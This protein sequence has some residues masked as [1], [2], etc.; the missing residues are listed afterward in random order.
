MINIPFLVGA[1]ESAAPLAEYTP[2]AVIMRELNSAFAFSH[3][4][5]LWGYYS[6]VNGSGVPINKLGID[7]KKDLASILTIGDGSDENY[8]F[9]GSVNSDNMFV[10]TNKTDTHAETWAE[11]IAKPS[12]SIPFFAGAQE[13]FTATNKTVRAV[14]VRELTSAFEV[15]LLPAPPGTILNK[16]YFINKS[17][18]FYTTNVNLPPKAMAGRGPWYDLYSQA[19]HIAANPL[20][21]YTFAYDDALAQDGTLHDDGT[22]P[23]LAQ[24][25][26]GN[27]D[28]VTIPTPK[29]NSG[30]YFPYGINFNFPSTL[31]VLLDGVQIPN[32]Y[33]ASVM[34]MPLALTVN[35]KSFKLYV[36][37]VIVEPP[38]SDA[39]GIVVQLDGITGSC[40]CNASL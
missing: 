5:F 14:I 12:T 34:A 25:T 10:F 13:S 30:L 4:D 2:Q 27:L 15:G 28:G 32:Y 26:I 22:K 29:I 31:T 16:D 21:V 40:L 38:Y 8:T 37:P 18:S 1:Q 7:T 36:D 24:I 3:T 11:A 39:E 23:H 19:L 17:S 33:T 35:G 6:K 9:W 20:P